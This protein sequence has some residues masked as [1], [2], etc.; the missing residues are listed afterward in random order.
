M[1][2]PKTVGI[3][4]WA[5]GASP[6]APS[7]S[8]VASDV[9]S[10][11]LSIPVHRCGARSTGLHR[12]GGRDHGSRAA[13][14]RGAQPSTGSPEILQSLA[15]CRDC[16]ERSLAG[17]RLATRRAGRRCA[18]WFR[19]RRDRRRGA[20]VLRILQRRSAWLEA[21]DSVRH[22][23]LDRRDDLERDFDLARAARHQPCSVDRLHQL[24]RRDWLCRGADPRGGR[25]RA[26]DRGRRR[27]RHAGHDFRLFQDEGRRHEV[28]R[29]AG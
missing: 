20:S 28:Q 9:R 23:R 25:R 4:A 8:A 18:G 13:G 1:S 15:H 11:R 3:A 26:A 24:D 2:P 7:V 29:R 27:L 17:C 6:R 22:S 14:A 12:R 10:K 19:R 16:R 21:R 5:L